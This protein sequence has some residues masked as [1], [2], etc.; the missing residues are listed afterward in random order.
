M[1]YDIDIGTA[2]SSCDFERA[3]AI[4]RHMDR[5]ETWLSSIYREGA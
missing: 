1:Q 2:D 3:E 4:G 5:L